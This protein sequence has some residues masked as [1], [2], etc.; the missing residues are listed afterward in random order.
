MIDFKITKVQKILE[1]N[2]D[3]AHNFYYLY[4]G[5]FYNKKK[6]KY[7]KFKFVLWFDIFDVQEWFFDKDRI[8][9]EDIKE[10]AQN[11]EAPFVYSIKNYNDTENLKV[12]YD[13]CKE[14]IQDYNKI[15]RYY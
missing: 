1:V 9:K 2:N 11:M 14:S 7:K 4:Y 10:F 15:A 12:F 6:T 5:R 13:F 3:K 8:T